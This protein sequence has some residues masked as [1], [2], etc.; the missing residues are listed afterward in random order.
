MRIIKRL[1]NLFIMKKCFK[2][3]VYILVKNV[4]D[5]ADV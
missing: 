1:I 2:T 3:K 5:V 4:A